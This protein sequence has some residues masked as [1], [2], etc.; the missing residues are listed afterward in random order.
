MG[1]LNFGI[2]MIGGKIF[3]VSGISGKLLEEMIIGVVLMK[4]GEEDL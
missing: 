2:V 4:I 1:C 3:G